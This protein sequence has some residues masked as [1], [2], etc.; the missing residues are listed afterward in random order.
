MTKDKMAKRTV[1][2]PSMINIHRQDEMPRSPSIF[3]WMPALMRPPKALDKS[4][5]EYR[6]AI[7]NAS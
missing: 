4:D 3:A 7:L 5:P 2:A 1:K 6:I